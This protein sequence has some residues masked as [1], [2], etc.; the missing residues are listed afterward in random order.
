MTLAAAVLLVLFATGC[1]AQEQYYDPVYNACGTAAVQE[2]P[3]CNYTLPLAQRV[4][5]FVSR[6]TTEQVVQQMVTSAPAIEELTLPAYDY[7]TEGLHGVLAFGATSFPQVIGLGATFNESLWLEIGI[8]ISTEARG[9]YQASKETQGLTIF[10]PNGNVFRDPRWGRGQETPGEDP[11]LTAQYVRQYVSGIQGS[12]ADPLYDPRYIKAV[13]TC[14]HY[15]A[16][17]LELWN[18]M[19]RH[20]FNAI[21]SDQDFQETYLPVFQA[22]VQEAHAKSIMCSYN[23]V[24]G[25]PA[26]ANTLLQQVVARGEWGF[27]GYIVSDCGAISDIQN[28]HNYTDN[29]WDTCQVAIEGGCDLDC[30]QYYP[31]CTEALTHGTLQEEQL[32]NALARVLRSRFELGLFDPPAEV[33]YQRLGMEHVNTAEHQALALQAAHQSI[34]LLQNR[35][36]VLPLD[37]SSLS[38][39]ALVGP[40]AAAK[41]TLLGDYH[42][43]PPG[44][45]SVKDALEQRNVVVNFAKGCS[46]LGNSTRGFSDALAAA[47]AS[48]LTIAVLGIDQHVEREGKDRYHITLPGKQE[49]LVQMLL[50]QTSTPL[51]VVLINGGQVSSPYIK[52]N[53]DSIVEAFYPGELGGTAVVDVLFGDYNPAGRLPYT[54]YQPE[55]VQQV[56]MLDMNMRASDTSVGRTYKFYEEEP[57]WEFGAGLSYTNFSYSFVPGE[58]YNYTLP[59]GKPIY[60]RAN[61]T[62]TGSIAGDEV[63]L[64]FYEPAPIAPKLPQRQLFGFTR[65]HL[66]PGETKEVVFLM[67]TGALSLVA[68]DGSRAVHPGAHTITIG[69]LRYPLQLHGLAQRISAGF[70][71]QPPPRQ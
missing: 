46:V 58:T 11:F 6:L 31:Q 50:N 67:D 17:S 71:S 44:V 52:A 1:V 19:D 37:E 38:S 40:N 9:L 61:V 70:P 20:H 48:D 29:V 57:V 54:V 23:E 51:V 47:Q 8:A 12:P 28:T 45:V 21:V 32:R 4:Q 34:V 66:Q 14:K 2:M 26:C 53:V 24:N 10:A 41:I 64:A 22:C 15:D 7:W 65:M 49:E 3:F 60:Y 27:E 62:N 68:E 16:Y 25:V 56:S 63:V 5:D 55:Y 33:S 43:L 39:V 42:G 69:P 35:K 18:G 59:L 30:G 13:A 36:A